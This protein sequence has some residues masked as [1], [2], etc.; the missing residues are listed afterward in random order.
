MPRKETDK[1]RRF[2]LTNVL[3]DGIIK[4]IFSIFL[5]NTTGWKKNGKR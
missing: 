1:M 3:C 5:Q 2:L 4:D